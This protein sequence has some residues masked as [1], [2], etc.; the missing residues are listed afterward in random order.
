MATSR[1]TG[2]GAP[3]DL[4]PS[5]Y[6]VGFGSPS[7]LADAGGE[8]GW[9]SPLAPTGATLATASAIVA[10]DGGEIRELDGDFS[11]HPGPY[12]VTIFDGPDGKEHICYGAVMGRGYTCWPNTARTKLP[13]VTP[14]LRVGTYS[15][16]V[17]GGDVPTATLTDVLTVVRRTW[18]S[19]V[20]AFRSRFPDEA[21]PT[22]AQHVTE[23]PLLDG[24]DPA[25]AISAELRAAFVKACGEELTELAG[26]RMT[27]L[28]A[29]LGPTATTASV[30]TVY[31]LPESGV[32]YVEGLDEPRVAYGGVQLDPPALT[33]LTRSEY[34]TKTADPGAV[35][36]DWSRTFSD[37]EEARADL[38]VATA[39]GTALAELGSGEYGVGKGGPWMTDAT[40]REVVLAVAYLDC[41]PWWSLFRV[42][43]AWTK[44]FRIAA[45]STCSG[46]TI[47]DPG[48]TFKAGHVGRLVRVTGSDGVQRL[49]RVQSVTPNTSVTLHG[50]NGPYWVGAAYA[51]EMLSWEMLPFVVERRPGRLTVRVAMPA[52]TM[53]PPHY[54]QDHDEADYAAVTPPSLT[55]TGVNLAHNLGS[56]G[57]TYTGYVLDPDDDGPNADGQADI[58]PAEPFY[59]GGGDLGRLRALLED[60]IAE[61]VHLTVETMPI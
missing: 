3:D 11:G 8:T 10:D 50:N 61:G 4:A 20:Y 12:V 59:A 44:Q 36:T 51:P 23:E 16:R 15:L 53:A 7:D 1:E 57:G 27:R 48:S 30:E 24:V 6:D 34:E 18:K 35:V 39:E 43:D 55:A 19:E 42:L 5:E 46:A 32:V 47:S 40:Y 25:A 58:D 26:Y 33:G 45:T 37:L 9:G 41:G 54:T 21:F 17:E 22:G 29:S 49:H 52:S 31:G 14:P 56:A 2:F 38:H 13:F 60:V 28:T